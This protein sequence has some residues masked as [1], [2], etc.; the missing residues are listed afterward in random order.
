MAKRK[1]KKRSLSAAEWEQLASKP[2]FQ[3]LMRKKKRFII[4]ATIFFILYYFALP[5]GTGYFTFLNTPIIGS[6]NGAYLFALSQF[7]MAWILAILYVR[8]ANK[9][10]QL[11]E[12]LIPQQR[13]KSS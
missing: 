11:I 12:E 10:D 13:R 9:L 5:I 7:F 6:L 3:E 2:H 8:H 1:S 4:S